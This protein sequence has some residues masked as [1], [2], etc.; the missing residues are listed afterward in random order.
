PTLA[1]KDFWPQAECMVA[2]LYG[3]RLFGIPQYLE[4]FAN[5]WGFV[6]KHLIVAGVGEWRSLV[7]HAGEPIDACT[8]QPWKDGY[9][10]GRSLTECVRLIKLFLA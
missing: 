4:A 1:D 8:G 6:R 2:F 5:I 10:T 7:N 9:H 3:Y